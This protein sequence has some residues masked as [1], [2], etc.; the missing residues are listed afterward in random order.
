MSAAKRKIEAAILQMEIAAELL[1][2]AL[3][4]PIVGDDERN[5]VNA[6]LRNLKSGD[7]LLRAVH[8]SLGMDDTIEELRRDIEKLQ[9]VSHE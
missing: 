3:D 4:A 5:A 7:E 2:G 1:K 8:L 6:V 9:E